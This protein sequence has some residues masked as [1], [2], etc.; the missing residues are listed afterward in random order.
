MTQHPS[1]QSVPRQTAVAV[2][3]AAALIG[4]L[5]L[6]TLAAQHRAADARLFQ[7]EIEPLARGWSGARTPQSVLDAAVGTAGG[8]VVTDAQQQAVARAGQP[9]FGNDPREVAP[10]PGSLARV[11]MAGRTYLA[12]TMRIGSDGTQLYYARPAQ[13]WPFVP[14]ALLVLVLAGLMAGGTF[15]YV[16]RAV[17]AS[18]TAA[19]A[20]LA[21]LARPRRRAPVRPRHRSP[22]ASGGHGALRRGGRPAVH[23]VRSP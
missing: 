20:D 18:S 19:A 12:G 2:A 11:E 4:V 13:P 14:P 9:I 21:E 23:H 7:Q 5:A 8:A 10:T 22:L 17:G 15:W 6:A 1:F 3:L 16:R